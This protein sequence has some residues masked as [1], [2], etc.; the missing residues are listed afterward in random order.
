MYDDMRVLIAC[1]HDD[2]NE[3]CLSFTVGIVNLQGKLLGMKDMDA[4]VSFATD[5]NQI[6][7]QFA[8]DTNFDALVV[9]DTMLG[10]NPDFVM[11]SLQDLH[12]LHFVTTV[13]PHAGVDWDQLARKLK[14]DI[15]EELRYRGLKYN[16][17]LA[18]PVKENSSRLLVEKAELK[19]FVMDRTVIDA[20]KAQAPA[21]GEDKHLFWADAVVQ[22]ELKDCSS[23]FM[24]MWGKE[25]WA[26]VEHPTSGFGLQMFGG[27]VG[28]RQ[29]IR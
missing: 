12:R 26:D 10:L 18:A 20:V 29:R 16:V 11:A 3:A 14:Q 7:N 22:G 27:C 15:A 2:R 6:I 25:V 8:N 21:C 28:Y 17:K 4:V 9:V 24:H 23:N 1:L 19:T 13:Y 5:K